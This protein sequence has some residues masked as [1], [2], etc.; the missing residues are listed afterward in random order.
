[1][2]IEDCT[3]FEIK[4][5]EK[6]D[7]R[8]GDFWVIMSKR[9]CGCCGDTYFELEHKDYAIRKLKDWIEKKRDELNELEKLLKE[10]GA[11]K[12]DG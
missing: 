3:Y 10:L 6:D 4:P 7:D 1:M 11:K 2:K 8:N 9:G 5:K 12:E